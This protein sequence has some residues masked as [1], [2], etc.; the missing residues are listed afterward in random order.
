MRSFLT[1]DEVRPLVRTC[2]DS[3]IADLR[4]LDGGSVKGVYRITLDDG[5][6]VLVYRWHA[7]EN[8][9]PAQ[10]VIDIGPFVGDPGRGAFLD[11]HSLLSSLAV[12]V[13]D[14]LGLGGADLALIEDV[15]NGTLEQS[16]EPRTFALLQEMLL[17]MHSHRLPLDFRCED[18]ILERGRRALVEAAARI[19]RIAAVQEPL[20]YEL[21]RRFAAIQPRSEHGVIH[22][23]LG[24]DHVLVDDDGVPVLID[25]EG[26]MVFDV[27]WEHAFLELRYESRY[28][29][30]RTVPL[31]EA[32]MELYRLVMWLT[33]VAG[34]L[35]LVDGDFPRPEG[36]RQIA[37]WNVERVL[38]VLPT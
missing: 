34:P 14:L 3:P 5:S 33:L 36:M 17:R 1:I 20:G 26:A 15:R 8:F 4:R 29:L 6:T 27:E 24:P 10:T 11:R 7:D 21:S 28:P 22:A 30:L 12:R 38:S 16:P 35:L 9:W 31:D 18:V 23:E 37:A 19:P 32:R 25:I 2:T 13:P